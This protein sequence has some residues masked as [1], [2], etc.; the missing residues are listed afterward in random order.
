MLLCGFV[1]LVYLQTH[2]ARAEKAPPPFSVQF[3]ETGSHFFEE[4][5]LQS[6]DVFFE[7]NRN[8]VNYKKCLQV[9]S[10]VYVVQL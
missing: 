6:M 1:L 8:T 7:K 9:C 2:V 3:S 5:S 10:S 4:T